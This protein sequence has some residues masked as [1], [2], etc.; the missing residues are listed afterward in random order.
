[1]VLCFGLKSLPCS[2]II[3]TSNKPNYLVSCRDLIIRSYVPWT[4]LSCH[5]IKEKSYDTLNITDVL[6][7]LLSGF[8]RVL[9]KASFYCSIAGKHAGPNKDGEVSM[10]FIIVLISPDADGWKTTEN[11]LCRLHVS[12]PLKKRDYFAYTF[13]KEILGFCNKIWMTRF[14][15]PP[16]PITSSMTKVLLSLLISISLENIN[17]VL[18]LVSDCT[19]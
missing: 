5:V 12:G 7:I 4:L 9:F 15:P 11:S 3:F 1:M 8:S 16:N 6:I 2:K 17:K 18:K 10:P 19:K 14:T 13:P